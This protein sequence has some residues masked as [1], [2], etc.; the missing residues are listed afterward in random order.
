MYRAQHPSKDQRSSSHGAQPKEA[1]KGLGFLGSQR[2]EPCTAPEATAAEALEVAQ[3]Q[4]SAFQ[5][6]WESRVLFDGAL[7]FTLG[8]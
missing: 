6:V 8:G 7:G 2:P 3:T 1:V 5:W 4:A